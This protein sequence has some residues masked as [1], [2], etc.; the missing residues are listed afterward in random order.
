MI[1]QA[2]ANAQFSEQ[3]KKDAQMKL[4]KKIPISEASVS[5]IRNDFTKT[6]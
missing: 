6:L 1:R 2:K 4:M 3:K 5:D